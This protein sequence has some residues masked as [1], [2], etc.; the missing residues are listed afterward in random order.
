MAGVYEVADTVE[1][2][3]EHYS[4][5]DAE[6]ISGKRRPIPPPPRHTSRQLEPLAVTREEDY[7]DVGPSANISFT[8]ITGPEYFALGANA[9]SSI[10]SDPTD[11]PEQAGQQSAPN[12]HSYHVLDEHE[13]SCDPMYQT[14]GSSYPEEEEEEEAAFYDDPTQ[15]KYRVSFLYVLHL[16]TSS[17]PP[18]FSLL[19]LLYLSG[20]FAVYCVGC[21]TQLLLFFLQNDIYSDKTASL[22][23]AGIYVPTSVSPLFSLSHSLSLSFSL[24]LSLSIS[25]LHFRIVLQVFVLSSSGAESGIGRRL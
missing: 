17:L 1:V 4:K 19:L 18:Y 25:Q 24:S 2:S 6:G 22:L 10:Y 14:V 3:C 11:P 8:H 21:Q 20:L 23:A 5:V 7:A 13:R 15:P 16:S 12:T 9:S